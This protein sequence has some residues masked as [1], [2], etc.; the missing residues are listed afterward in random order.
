MT[1]EESESEWQQ[2]DRASYETLPGI[3]LV[4]AALGV[5]LGVVLLIAGE[6]QAVTALSVPLLFSALAIQLRSK[7]G[8]WW[9]A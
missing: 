7:Q 3:L 9:R 2:L 4:I 6:T 8:G 1:P 5:V